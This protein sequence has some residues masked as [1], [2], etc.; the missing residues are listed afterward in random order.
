MPPDGPTYN[1]LIK[2]MTSQHMPDDAAKIYKKMI[3]SNI[4]PSIHTYNMMI[5]SYFTS[6]NY[7]M[8]CALG[9]D[10]EEGLLS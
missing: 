3:L 5:K 1:A 8:G 2:I 10:E 7:E 9:G 4:Q 6:R